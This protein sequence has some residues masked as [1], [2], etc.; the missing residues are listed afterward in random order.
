MEMTSINLNSG[1]NLHYS[2]LGLGNLFTVRRRLGEERFLVGA[3]SWLRR[4]RGPEQPTARALQPSNER[5]CH[6]NTN[7]GRGVS[8]YGRVVL[9]RRHHRRERV[10][11]LV[12]HLLQDNL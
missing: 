7:S 12:R 4:S 1:C 3:A 5:Q 10:R 2:T 6:R 8:V 9:H 11:A